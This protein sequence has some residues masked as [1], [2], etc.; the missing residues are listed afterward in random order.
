MAFI[1][2]FLGI[3]TLLNVFLKISSLVKSKNNPAIMA[4]IRLQ[5]PTR[6]KVLVKLFLRLKFC[7]AFSARAFEFHGAC[8]R[9][10]RAI[11]VFGVLLKGTLDLI[12]FPAFFTYIF[13][14]EGLPVVSSHVA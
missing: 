14:E 10:R 7:P 4:F 2:S 12:L 8:G 3:F 1:A 5:I 13:H 6:G 9:K 11:T